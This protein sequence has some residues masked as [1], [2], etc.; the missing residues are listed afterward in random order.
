MKIE[1]KISTVAMSG[2][3]HESDFRIENDGFLYEVL[4]KMYSNPL[5]S[6]IREISTNA[7]DSHKMANINDPFDIILPTF[8][9][10]RI[11]IKDHGVGMSKEE[12]ID[13]YLVYGKSTKRNSNLVTGCLGL[14][15]KTPFIIS[16]IFIVTSI[17]DNMKNILQCEFESNIPKFVWLMS[18]EHTNELNGVTIDIPLSKAYNNDEIISAIKEELQFF[19]IKPNILNYHKKEITYAKYDELLTIDNCKLIDAVGESCVIMNEIKYN[20]D[21]T[22]LIRLARNLE[23]NSELLRTI[24]I[25]GQKISLLLYIEPGKVKFNPSREH[26]IFDTNTIINIM[27]QLESMVSSFNIQI[28][29]YFNNMDDSSKLKQCFVNRQGSNWQL[30]PLLY[31][32]H[33]QNGKI[34]LCDNTISNIPIKTL[35]EYLTAQK[36]IKVD[37]CTKYVKTVDSPT[38]ITNILGEIRNFTILH[39]STKCVLKTAELTQLKNS[40]DQLMYAMILDD[41]IEDH[42]AIENILKKSEKYIEPVQYTRA[43][44]NNIRLVPDPVKSKN[45]RFTLYG[46]DGYSWP[47]EHI[48]SHNINNQSYVYVDH[49]TVNKHI[50]I[51]YTQ[52]IDAICKSIGFYKYEGLITLKKIHKKAMLKNDITNGGASWDE[53]I[54]EI[55]NKIKELNVN[56]TIVCGGDDDD[57]IIDDVLNY[58]GAID[59]DIIS[60][61]NYY[62]KL[63]IKFNKLRNDDYIYISKYK[64]KII[65]KFLVNHNSKIKLKY[66]EFNDLFPDIQKINEIV[67][68]R[69]PLLQQLYSWSKLDN[70]VKEYI[71][72]YDKTKGAFTKARFNKIKGEITKS[73]K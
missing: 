10:N 55:L 2:E 18:N 41:N 9:D 48:Y 17:K 16:D 51:L 22:E 64:M 6:V 71:A 7:K 56:K 25:M 13:I 40:K 8:N 37:L 72:M 29:Q 12:L 67:K 47:C 53:Y 59:D 28:N 46:L 38:V 14:G 62:K 4:T 61:S 57:K 63:I 35:V 11:M 69:Y 50:N 20:I 44:S 66:K 70:S 60:N 23:Y 73:E 52:N 27:K 24:N 65:E 43:K 39:S 49:D 54:N 42:I 30:D 1:K 3:L 19:K 31:I 58:Y 5:N 32:A 21:L 33:A 15:S 34:T 36:I 45:F 26:L 68:K